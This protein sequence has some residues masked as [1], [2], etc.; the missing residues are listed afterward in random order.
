MPLLGSQT[1]LFTL[2]SWTSVGSL[3]SQQMS[4]AKE[5]KTAFDA[6][7]IRQVEAY[8]R[9]STPGTTSFLSA[10]HKP[11]VYSG[12]KVLCQLSLAELIGE[13]YQRKPYEVNG[14]KWLNEDLFIFQALVT[15]HSS[16]D[17]ARSMMQSALAVRFG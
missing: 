16:K 17:D 7:L 9:T 14:P 11:C 6:V 12:E 8:Q 10:P 2:M 15:E 3:C 1:L 4:T 5:R 13:A